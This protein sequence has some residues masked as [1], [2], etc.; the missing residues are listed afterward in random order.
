MTLGE[1]K[2]FDQI[3]HYIM[4]NFTAEGVDEM[5]GL[6]GRP[7]LDYVIETQP[8]LIEKLFKVSGIITDH[9]RLLETN[10]IPLI[11]GITVLY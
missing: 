2:S 11:L 6:L 5:I 7:F 10:T 3:Y 4:D 1:E 8:N 9:T